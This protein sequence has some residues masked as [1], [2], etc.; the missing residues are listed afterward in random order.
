MR[1]RWGCFAAALAVLFALTPAARA[2]SCGLPRRSPRDLRACGR[3]IHRTRRSAADADAVPDADI[4]DG[5]AQR[6]R[7]DIRFAVDEDFKV[8]LPDEITVHGAGSPC[9]FGSPVGKT[10]AMY[11]HRTT[12]AGPPARAT[13]RRRTSCGRWRHPCLRRT[14]PDRRVSSWAAAWARF[15]RSRSMPVDARWRYARAPGETSSLD[16][17]PGRDV[18][19]ELVRGVVSRR[20]LE[21]QRRDA[22]R[23]D[24]RRA[25]RVRSSRRSKPKQQG[26]DAPVRS[27]ASIREGRTLAVFGVN[28]GRVGKIVRVDGEDETT[29]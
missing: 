13:R 24:A 5:P 10:V 23:P 14:D 6:G 20:V 29:I 2:C 22:R 7:D 1:V 15:G 27:R 9:G 8:D 18:V 25:D 21:D 12:V 28:D 17:C 19:A 11:L 4:I 16:L 26:L 3:S